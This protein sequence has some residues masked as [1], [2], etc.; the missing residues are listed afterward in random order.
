MPET[1]GTH[2]LW[3]IP[4]EQPRL[5]T[6]VVHVWCL[7]LDLPQPTIESLRTILPP[8]EEA[9][10]ARFLFDRHRR[11]FI[12]CRGQVRQ[13]LARYL[14]ALPVEIRFRY[15]TQGKPSL[16]APSSDAAIQFN[17]SNSHELA[18][19]ALVLNR[20]LGV[21]LEYIHRLTDFDGL[22]DRFFAVR[23]V[24]VMRA[25]PEERRREAFFN[26]W[27]RKEAVLKAVGIGLSMPLNQVEVTLAPDAPAQVL[28]Y[29]S[30]GAESDP[31]WLQSLDPATGYQGAIASRGIPLQIKTWRFDA[32]AQWLS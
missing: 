3:P 26:C 23:E 4:S 1:S 11:R 14:S 24:E 27:T 18:L 16:A 30:D 29:A 19:C 25:L 12:A 6:G 21:D 9:R 20:D 32:A 31:W 15:G 7:P 2:C 22:A 13:I 5:A 28:A 17:V 8:D 10:A